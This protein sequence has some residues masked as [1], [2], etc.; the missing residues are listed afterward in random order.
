MSNIAVLFNRLMYM[1][2]GIIHNPISGRVF[3]LVG[4]YIITWLCNKQI[5]TKG[6]ANTRVD[7]I[8]MLGKK[9][10]KPTFCR[11]EQ[12]GIYNPIRYL[13]D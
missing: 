1:S 8:G 12:Q 4:P 7:N 5:V 11:R 13:R 9:L 10:L 2:L 3:G 6:H